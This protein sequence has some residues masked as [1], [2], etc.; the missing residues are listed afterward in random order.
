MIILFSVP[1]LADDS[2]KILVTNLQLS[3]VV[4]SSISVV[5]SSVGNNNNYSQVKVPLFLGISGSNLQGNIYYSGLAFDPNIT[6]VSQFNFTDSN[7]NRLVP[8]YFEPINDSINLSRIDAS[9]FTIYFNN[10]FSRSIPS[11]RAELIGYFVFNFQYNSENTL[12]I[13]QNNTFNFTPSGSYVFMTS[14]SF[15]LVDSIVYAINHSSEID[16][17]VL[18]LSSINSDILTQVVPQ[19]SNINGILG[20]IYNRL[21][22]LKLSEIQN[23]R[24][25]IYALSGIDMTN[26]T[27]SALSQATYDRWVHLIYD[28]INYQEPNA[29]EAD[30]AANDLQSA[31]DQN[32]LAQDQA[33]QG[34]DSAMESI[35]F[36]V[37]I[38]QGIINAGLTV[39]NYVESIY[40]NLGTDLQFLITV[41]LTIGLIT[42]I[43]G[44]INRYPRSP[45][46]DSVSEVETSGIKNGKRVHSKTTTYRHTTRVRK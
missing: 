16:Q 46:T 6:L 43:I 9:N 40:T 25:L 13:C 32:D 12:V 41:T 24:T 39:G 23:M 44:A 3:F 8:Q 19:L 7:N 36:Q 1:V 27:S 28:A 18:V 26:T 17:I 38:P 35:D 29:S 34:M 33:Y 45:V 31:H 30:Q 20:S 37:T 42:V 22:E 5:S 4:D 21:N 14:S 15:G 2:S 10:Y 11:P